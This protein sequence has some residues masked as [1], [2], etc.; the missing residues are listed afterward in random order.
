MR[1]VPRWYGVRSGATRL[2][3]A[4]AVLA[5]GLAV[6]IEPA[7][8]AGPPLYP[9]LRTS[10]PTGLY[11]DTAVLGDG[12]THYLLR[13]DNEVENH[14]GPL[15][16]TADLRQSRY[17]YQNVYDKYTGGAMVQSFRIGSDL[18]YHPTH[19]H[20]HFQDFA[21][22]QLLKK[23]ARGVYRGTTRRGS[24]TSFCII[25]YARVRSD[26]GPASPR[27][28]ICD[29]Q[30]QGLSA[31]WSDIY[32]GQLPEQWIDVGTT[33]LAD[34]DYAIKSVANPLF[35]IKESENANNAALTYFTVRNGAILTTGIPPAC[36]VNPA[37]G[38]TG[39]SILVT[40]TRFTP[41]QT[42]NI[43]WGSV[44]TT[45]RTTA[46]VDGNGT[47]TATFIAPE[48]TLGNHYVIGRSFDGKE[49]AATLFATTASLGHDL[50]AGPVGSTVTLAM[51]GFVASESIAVKYYRTTSSSSTLA[52]VTAS[53]KGSVGAA[54]TIP[55]STFGGHK[56]E[57]VGLTSGAKA[58]VTFSVQPSLL[59]IPA[60]GEGGE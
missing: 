52:T 25:D 41:D 31:G 57:A 17:V 26:I 53:T 20:F 51:Y 56:I 3:L 19:N 4:L 7:T 24:K 29:D 30:K 43:Y 2:L 40:C 28:E 1:I 21:S 27:Y 42:L 38:P 45:P 59:L 8:T 48:G 44:N 10:S 5:A 32:V 23:D 14:G 37:S 47:A 50:A 13:F 39:T 60:A 46:T 54:I 11:F 34:G 15:E 9:D 49:Q 18:I 36:D 55:A 22:Y 6:V 16:I 12:R 35:K 33:R 58:A